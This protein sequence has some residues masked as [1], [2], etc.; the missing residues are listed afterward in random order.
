MALPGCAPGPWQRAAPRVQVGFGLATGPGGDR[1][2]RSG[3]S[4]VTDMAR[5]T[6]NKAQ[7]GC[8]CQGQGVPSADRTSA[9]LPP[10]RC[11]ALERTALQLPAGGDRQGNSILAS[12]ALHQ[13][14]T[15]CIPTEVNSHPK[16]LSILP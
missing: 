12:S 11:D 13:D 4:A 10:S 7:S 14:L 16:L 2:E 3:L 6:M 1:W 8:C 9:R 5:L 15:G